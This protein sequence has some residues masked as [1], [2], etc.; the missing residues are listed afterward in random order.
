V[1]P[2]LLKQLI[3]ALKEIAGAISGVAGAIFFSAVMRAFF[4]K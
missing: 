1:D 2:E 3:S 4:N